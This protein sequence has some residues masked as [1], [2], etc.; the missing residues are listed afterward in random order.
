M[1]EAFIVRHKYQQIMQ[2]YLYHPTHIRC[3]DNP[4]IVV[5][6]AL[7]ARQWLTIVMVEDAVDDGVAAAGNIDEQ[8]SGGVDVDECCSVGCVWPRAVCQV[9]F[10]RHQ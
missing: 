5:H 10:V 4:T 8:L 1:L 3:K 6:L 2:F 9:S 7:I